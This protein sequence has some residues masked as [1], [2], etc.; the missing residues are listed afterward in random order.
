MNSYRVICEPGDDHTIEATDRREALC[1]FLAWEDDR[2]VIEIDE[3]R[4]GEYLVRREG[5]ASPRRV[6]VEPV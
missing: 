3:V 6:T 2:E 4:A 1:D 5:D